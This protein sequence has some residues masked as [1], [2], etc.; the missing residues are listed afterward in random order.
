MAFICGTFCRVNDRLV[1]SKQLEHTADVPV[2]D[3]DQRMRQ[4][5]AH[6]RTNSL[7]QKGQGKNVQDEPSRN[8]K[9]NLTKHARNSCIDPKTNWQ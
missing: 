6:S 1:G 3:E 8:Q 2:V 9:I 4:Q 5:V 7:W